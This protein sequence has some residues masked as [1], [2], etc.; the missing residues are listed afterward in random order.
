MLDLEGRVISWNAGAE[1]IKGYAA[2]E[3]IGDN[4]ARFYTPEERDAGAP[5]NA[6]RFSTSPTNRPSGLR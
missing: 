6:L 3:I 1:K 2:A 5:Q 4:F